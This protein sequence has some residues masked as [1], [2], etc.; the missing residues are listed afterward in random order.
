ML[1]PSVAPAVE[2]AGAAATEPSTGPLFGRGLLYVAVWALQLLS[3]VVFAPV[4]AHLLPPDQFGQLAAGIAVHQ[5]LVVAAVVGLDQV[6]VLLRA[7]DGVDRP[8]RALVALGLGLGV[9]VT[10]V[11]VATLPWWSGPLGFGEGSRVLLV[12]VAW[13]APAACLQL[14]S[15][16]LLAQDRFR[17]FSVVTLLSGVGGQV[18]GMALL[19]GSGSRVAGTYALG[20]LVTLSLALVVGLLM[21]RPGWRAALGPALARR[22]LS[23]GVPLMIG[24]LA[25][26]VLNAGDRI[27]VQRLLGSAEAGRYQIAY[28]IG[29]VVVMLLAVTSGAWAPRIAA[30]RDESH[31]WA[32]IASARDGLVRLMGPVILGLTLGAPFVLDVVA[33]ASYDTGPLLP[34]VLLVALAGFPV[35][36]SAAT[37]RALITLRATAPLAVAAGVAAVLNVGLNLVLVPVWELSGA[38]AATVVAFA[39]QAGVQRL[40]LARRATL[41]RLLPGVWVPTAVAVAVAVATLE[42]PST[43]TWDAARAAAGLACLPWLVVQLRVLRDTG[44]PQRADQPG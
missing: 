7:E 27:V 42:L 10:L 41:P 18:V 30:I 2:P 35:L 1:E 33:P 16:L 44:D 26:Y 4:L 29:N 5:V 22:A 31:R 21:V 28:T 40:A 43:L 15:A 34:V 14:V 13:T 25:V 36:A 19:L 3:S 23:L 32:V 37:G 17:A 38:A 24:S 39:A 11:A 20:N 12:T 6:L 8:A 9:L